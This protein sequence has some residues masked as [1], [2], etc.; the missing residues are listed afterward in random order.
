MNSRYRISQ[1]EMNYLYETAKARMDY[2][3]DHAS[4]QRKV[5]EEVPYFRTEKEALETAIKMT[6]KKPYSWQIWAEIELSDS[7]Y[8]ICNKWIVTDDIDVKLAADYIG[9]A[10]MYDETRISR[11]IDSGIDINEVIAY[12]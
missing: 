1:E 12:Y 7:V 4:S 2:H 3:P 11:I 6:E 8:R 9:M 5:L 10:L